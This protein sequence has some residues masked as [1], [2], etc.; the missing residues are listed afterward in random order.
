MNTFGNENIEIRDLIAK[1]EDIIRD[2]LNNK[3]CDELYDLYNLFRSDEKLLG[4]L[5]ATSYVYKKSIN[6]GKENMES[7]ILKMSIE[8]KMMDYLNIYTFCDMCMDNIKFKNMKKVDKRKLF[9]NA[10]EDLFLRENIELYNYDFIYHMLYFNKNLIMKEYE[11]NSKEFDNFDEILDETTINTSYFI[12]NLADEDYGNYVS[13]FNELAD[14]Y[15]KYNSYLMENGIDIKTNDIEHTLYYTRMIDMRK[16]DLLKESIFNSDVIDSF[17]K[18]YIKYEIL[19]KDAKD[20]IN[21]VEIDRKSRNSNTKIREF[22]W[23]YFSDVDEFDDENIEKYDKYIN[24][25]EESDI[26]DDIV[27]VIYNDAYSI[28]SYEYLINN[29]KDFECEYSYIKSFNDI[30]EFKIAMLEDKASLLNYAI[31]SAD[32]YEMPFLE[33]KNIIREL[34]ENCV[35]NDSLNNIYKNDIKYY[36]GNI[37]LEYIDKMYKEVNKDCVYDTTTSIINVK[38]TILLDIIE[39]K[40]TKNKK[41]FDIMY[42]ILKEYQIYKVSVSKNS[43]YEN[44]RYILES[45]NNDLYGFI[46]NIST[47]YIDYILNEYLVYLSLPLEEKV[48]LK[49]NFEEKNKRGK[50]KLIKRK[51]S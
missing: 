7:N 4:T 32:F 16:D 44:D 8:S 10:K 37:S 3:L 9:L 17:I 38:S 11:K 5:Y 35:Y 21:N 30:E 1:N 29:N 6:D 40:E 46:D 20:K 51:N 12:S 22:L 49:K 34:R 42:D 14:I 23:R 26:Y 27:D 15:Y 48:A 47:D 18:D 33:K 13:L 45:I 39:L 36:N 2:G 50:V 25:I 41:Y 24:A 28:I 43:I 31:C 19:A